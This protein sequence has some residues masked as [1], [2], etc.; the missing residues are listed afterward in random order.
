MCRSIQ[1]ERAACGILHLDADNNHIFVACCSW[2]N[3]K[4]TGSYIKRNGETGPK[5][6]NVLG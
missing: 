2:Q 6:A 5:V 4:M 3:S 1:F